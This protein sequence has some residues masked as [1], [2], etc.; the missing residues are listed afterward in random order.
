LLDH[1]T[2]K[3]EGKRKKQNNFS[4]MLYSVQRSVALSKNGRMPEK[5][6]SPYLTNELVKNSGGRSVRS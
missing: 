6:H 3:K 5:P 2:L 1:K 4:K